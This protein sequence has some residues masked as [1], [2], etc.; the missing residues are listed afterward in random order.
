M[1]AD[2]DGLQQWLSET[3]DAEAVVEVLGVSTAGARRRNVLFDAVAGERVRRCVATILPTADI[4][5]MSM[6][7][8][9]AVRSVARDHSVPVPEVISVCVDDSV[10]GGAFFVSER[11]E[12]E[13][14]PRKV[15]RLVDDVGVGERVVAQL[16][17]AM[18]RLHAIDSACAP[19]ALVRPEHPAA[20]ALDGV[21]L[22]TAALLQPEPAY[23]YGVRWLAEHHPHEPETASIVH[24]DIRT[25]N[26]IVDRSGLQAILDW[27][28]A[29]V[30]DPME[31]LAW[32]CTRMWRFGRDELTV[33]GLG[34]LAALR[35]AYEGAGGQWHEQRF[36]W[37]RV[38]TTLRW[39]LGLAGQAAMH[40]DGT[41]SSVVMAASGRRVSEMAFDALALIEEG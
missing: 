15:L 40:L 5:L 13:S 16:G 1:T 25:G 10:L 9:A 4:A 27:E 23:S 18:A 34:S 11:V 2:R 33:G 29:K 38:L 36:R 3:W 24:A 32:V 20:A 30:G 22:A 8:E 14:I 35:A 28:T 21:R 17:E 31:D 19:G 41:F 37:W 12:G 26:I 39:G 7:D 6:A